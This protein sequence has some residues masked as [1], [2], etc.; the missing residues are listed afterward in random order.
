MKEWFPRPEKPDH[1]YRFGEGIVSWLKRS[2]LPFADDCRELLNRNLLALPQDCQKAISDHLHHEQHHRDGFFE[3]I[4]GRAL[5]ELGADIECEPDNLETNRRP[6]FVARFPERMIIVEAVSPVMDRE[7]LAISDREAPMIKLVEENVPS[8]WVADIR[9]LP[10][11]GPDEPRRP[12]KAIL[13]KKL[14][15][16]P[17]N[18]NDEEVEIR[19]TFEQGDLRIILF[20]RSRHGLSVDTKIAFSNTMFH[21]PKDKAVLRG[22]V[23]RKYA[24][25]RNLGDPTL[26]AL[27]MSSMTSGREDLDQALFGITVSQRDHYGNEV[28]R[29]FQADGLFT[30][31]R[32][33][34]PTI[35]GVLAFPE[36]GFSRCADPILW[37]HPRFEGDF[38]Q[39]LKA[40]E[41]R[42]APDTGAEV[43]IEQAKRVDLL[44]NLRFVQRK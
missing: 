40:L 35:S 36:V 26:V 42:Y 13:R 23:K 14:H 39:A 43:S 33:E 12:L 11:V 2:T 6:D 10:N 28:G 15:M 38:P 1:A 34:E 16:P 5:Q 30:G 41:R 3:L 29:Y 19:E 44:K 9:A 27:N 8:G 31:G 32:R 25:L 18:R 22:A 21:W 24:Q 4:V 20:P 17:P 37:V 7:L